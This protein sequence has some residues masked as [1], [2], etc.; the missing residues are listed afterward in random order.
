MNETSLL[1]TLLFPV[2]HPIPPKLRAVTRELPEDAPDDRPGRRKNP[3]G[4]HNVHWN[5]ECKSFHIRV[6]VNGTRQAIYGFKTIEAAISA[7]D[8]LLTDLKA[9]SK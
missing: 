1:H 5:P 7:R 4:E 6:S 3:T 9:Q 8:K 2:I